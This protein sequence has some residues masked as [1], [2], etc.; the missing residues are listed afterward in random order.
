MRKVL[1]K[2]LLPAVAAGMLVF[3]VLHV[4][5]AQQTPPMPPPPVEPSRNPFGRTV[6]G[7]GIVEA[8]SDNISIGTALPGMVMEVYGPEKPGLPPWSSLIGRRVRKGDPLFRVDD[9][10]L[11]AQL[12]YQEANLASAR[13]QLAKLEAMP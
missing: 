10:Q 6:A 7:A 1:G 13:A 2:F 12:K 9:R 3:A 4:V 11:K 8:R 5:R